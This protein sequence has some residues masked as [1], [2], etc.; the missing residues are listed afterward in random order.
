MTNLLP[1][2]GSHVRWR[3]P[4]S[5]SFGL[6]RLAGPRWQRQEANSSCLCSERPTVLV[7][8][9][10]AAGTP[11]HAPVANKAAQDDVEK[12]SARRTEGESHRN[13]RFHP[14]RAWSAGGNG[15]ARRRFRSVRGLRLETRAFPQCGATP[16]RIRCV[17]R[18]SRRWMNSARSSKKRRSNSPGSRNRRP[19]LRP[20][21]P[22]VAPN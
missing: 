19:S 21:L 7:L 3:S 15:A 20:S 22:P 18:A 8:I 10:A 12:P 1:R 11:V 14:Q 9:D 4:G 5:A 16:R 2:G 13:A 17:H 6:M